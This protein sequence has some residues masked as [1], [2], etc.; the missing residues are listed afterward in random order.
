MN[1]NQ[2]KTNVLESLY[3]ISFKDLPSK[4]INIFL[5]GQATKNSSKSLRGILRNE[6]IKKPLNYKMLEIYYP[7][8][9]FD[10]LIQ[11]KK[12]FDLLDL[13]NML[14]DSVN[15]VV[16][17]LESP[18]SIA[19]LGAFSNN[20]RF[21][22]KLLVIVDKKYKRQKSF[23]ILGPIKYLNDTKNGK[24]IYWDFKSKNIGDLG[25]EIRREL[26]SIVNT[27]KVSDA[28]SNPILLQTYILSV[29]HIFDSLSKDELI[30]VL[31]DSNKFETTAT[32]SLDEYKEY[33][34]ISST[35]KI[36]LRNSE[37][38]LFNGKYI[39][40]PTGLERFRKSIQFSSNRIKIQMLL[41]K[42]RIETLNMQRK[43][44]QL[45]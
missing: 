14:A 9:I 19:E 33:K 40:S 29:L 10:E 44:I 2:Q 12:K 26:R 38:T 3:K 11:G 7:E 37:I 16:I 34:L 35:L 39:V 22:K 45:I 13:E 41:D 20:K 43:R 1:F 30:K 32:S 15:A 25:E 23:I 17:I 5:I 8:E 21:A 24:I 18:G 27:T 4:S 6:L 36:L 28:L 42:N 31:N